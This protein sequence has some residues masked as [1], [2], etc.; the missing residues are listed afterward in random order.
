[1]LFAH[2][3]KLSIIEPF[4]EQP[5]FPFKYA[6]F[7]G[8]LSIPSYEKYANGVSKVTFLSAFSPKKVNPYPIKEFYACGPPNEIYGNMKNYNAYGPT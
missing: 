1:M 3:Q 7:I 8:I 4:I 6:I 5:F 2:S